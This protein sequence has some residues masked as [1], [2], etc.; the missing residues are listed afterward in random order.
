MPARNAAPR[1]SPAS[2]QI[3]RSD[4]S[5]LIFFSF[6][7][8]CSSPFADKE[9]GTDSLR[10]RIYSKNRTSLFYCNSRC[11]LFSLRYLHT[12]MIRYCISNTG[13]V[14]PK[15]TTLYHS[16]PRSEPS[17]PTGTHGYCVAPRQTC[18]DGYT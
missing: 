14:H 15:T 18:F 3:K 10:T 11:L 6:R 1:I 5:F 16:A 2:I 17:L 9:E 12:G 7:L 13:M 8:H 4:T